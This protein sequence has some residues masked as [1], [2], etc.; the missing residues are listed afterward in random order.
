MTSIHGTALAQFQPVAD[1]FAANFAELDELGASLCITIEG[2]TVL[3][4][5]GGHRDAARTQD[6]DRDTVCVLFS[7]TKAATALCAQIL[8]DRCQLDL[9]AKVTDYWPEFGQ[10]GKQDATVL[11]LLNHTVGLPALR[12]EVKPDGY[13]DWAYMTAQL[14]AETP[15]WTPGSQ[16]GYHMITFGWLVGELVRRVSGQSLGQ[17]F[18]AQIAKPLG[19]PLWIGLPEEQDANLAPVKFF[20]MQPGERLSDFTQTVLKDTQSMQALSM[21]NLGGLDYNSVTA[22]RAEIGGAGG[23]GNARGLC[24][25]FTPLANGGGEL[26]S[27]A[28]ITAMRQES[29]SN[30]R[31]ANLLIPS[32]FGQGFMLSM[33]NE[34]S[35]QEDNRSFIIGA[36]AFGHVGAGGSTGFADPANHMAFSYVMNRMGGGFLMN[37]RGQ[38]LIDAAYAGL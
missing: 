15:F 1:L 19:L 34:S 27:E 21:L 13:A 17:F 29:S 36:D 10:N 22:H 14:A 12:D 3:D 24:G 28:R 23:I 32:R 18:D 31:D 6:W 9:N 5:W 16:T 2:E 8:I 11:M 4:M 7:N 30:T 35:S 25:M 33:D 38:R 20:K 37:E 26:L